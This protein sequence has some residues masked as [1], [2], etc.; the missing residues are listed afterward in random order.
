[1]SEDSEKILSAAA[2]IMASAKSEHARGADANWLAVQQLA[3][4]ELS[5]AYLSTHQQQGVDSELVK[6]LREFAKQKRDFVQHAEEEKDGWFC[7]MPP[8]V[9]E[10]AIQE[11]QMAERA[12]DALSRAALT[13]VLAARGKA[14]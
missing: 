5:E 1:M 12:A 14:G 2:G 7:T 10:S 11:A 6:D 3:I 13:A 8:E 4:H 9:A